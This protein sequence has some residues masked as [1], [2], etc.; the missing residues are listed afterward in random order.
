MRVPGGVQAHLPVGPG[1]DLHL[2]H[3]EPGA[4][5]RLRGFLQRPTPSLGLPGPPRLGSVV[6]LIGLGGALALEPGSNPARDV[7]GP[8]ACC[9]AEPAPPAPASRGRPQ[10][11]SRPLPA[12]PAARGL[13]TWCSV[14]GLEV[15]ISSNHRPQPN[16]PHLCLQRS[17]KGPPP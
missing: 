14:I 10:T 15:L 4:R 17:G 7:G 3:G 9:S 6:T 5:S 1:R 12:R 8:R 11:R 13:T 16:L 2:P